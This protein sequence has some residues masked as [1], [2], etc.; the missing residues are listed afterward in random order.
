MRAGQEL[1][2]WPTSSPPQRQAFTAFDI[3]ILVQH[4]VS[5]C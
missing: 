3:L 2:A 1:T 5:G 4:F